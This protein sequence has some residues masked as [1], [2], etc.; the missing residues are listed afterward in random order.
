MGGAT[1]GGGA[2]GAAGAGGVAGGTFGEPAC[3]PSV[4]S[5]ENCAPTDEQ[6]CYKR[7]GPDGV[8]VKS[9]TCQSSGLYT[10]M[11]GC[12]YDLSRDYSCYRI[13]MRA[14]RRLPERAATAGG[15]ALRAGA[16][17]RVQQSGGACRRRFASG[18]GAV[19]EGWCVCQ[20]ANAAGLRTWSCAGDRPG[21]ARSASAAEPRPSW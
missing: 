19:S 2:V 16:V 11:V 1:G 4:E 20:A 6:L 5:G 7:C 13:P 14:Q 21:P 18:A 15:S 9:E 3:A 17:H 12:A 8:G 10:E